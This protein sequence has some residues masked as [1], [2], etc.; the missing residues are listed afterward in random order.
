MKY[1]KEKFLLLVIS[2][3]LLVSQP[4]HVSQSSPII[5]STSNII[6]TDTNTILSETPLLD[7]VQPLE[8]LEK[9]VHTVT[10]RLTT[11]QK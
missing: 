3:F 2:I 10:D 4:A 7:L 6:K 9:N 1:Q 8:N 5:S 11:K